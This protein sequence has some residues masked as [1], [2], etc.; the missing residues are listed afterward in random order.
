LFPGI[1]ALQPQQ[2]HLFQSSSLFLSPLPM[3]LR[4]QNT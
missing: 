3:D 2:V 1:Q 4:L